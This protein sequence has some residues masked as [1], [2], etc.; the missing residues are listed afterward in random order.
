MN[1]TI[2]EF[3]IPIADNSLI[4]MPVYSDILKCINKNDKIVLCVQTKQE[5]LDTG[6]TCS[7]YFSVYGTGTFFRE[8][9]YYIATVIM[10]DGF[11]WHVLEQTYT[12]HWNPNQDL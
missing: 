7:R 4:T 2:L 11:V 1:T 10:S 6:L 5:Y 12:L 8:D 9:L 3:E